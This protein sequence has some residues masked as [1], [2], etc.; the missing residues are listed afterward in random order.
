MSAFSFCRRGD[1]QIAPCRHMRGVKSVANQ[2]N[3]LGYVVKNE[4]ESEVIINT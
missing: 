1:L 2:A 4:G 3:E